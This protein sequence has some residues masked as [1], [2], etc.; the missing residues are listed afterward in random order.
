MYENK[1]RQKINNFMNNNIMTVT[2]G[3]SITAIPDIAVI[4]LG[5]MT[6]GDM[7]SNVQEDNARISQMILEGLRQLGITDIK[8]YQYN[9]DKLY[10]YENGTRIDRGYFVRNIFEIR[11]DMLDMAGS[12]IDTAVSLG[13]NLVEL[14]SFEVSKIDQYYLEAL[15]LALKNATDKAKSISNELGAMLN[16]LP[17]SI[18]ENSGQPVPIARTF[19]GEGQITTPIEPGTTQIE[20]SVVLEFTYI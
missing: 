13:A 8:T 6:T 17:K 19:Y 20:A 11:T 16:P 7:L 9:V 14:I 12:I 2:G 5:T 10:E 15:N 4:R 3:G 18:V 1:D